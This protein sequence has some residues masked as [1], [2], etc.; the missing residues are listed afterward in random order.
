MA[1]VREQPI[2]V[3]QVKKDLLNPRGTSKT[4]DPE[5]RSALASTILGVRREGR[6][7]KASITE[8][9]QERQG[10][11]GQFN[12]SYPQEQGIAKDL[13]LR[14]EER[15]VRLKRKLGIGDKRASE[16]EAQ[17]MGLWTERSSISDKAGQVAHQVEELK[18]KQAEIPDPKELLKAYYE[19]Q[20]TQPLTNQ[21]KRELL[22]PEVLSSLTTEEY[23]ALWRRL[24]PY[25]LSHVTRQGFR[26]HNVMIYHSGGL[27]EFHNGFVSVLNDEKQLRPPL[28]I[29]GLRT[30]DEASVQA[31]LSNWVLEAPTQQDAQDRFYNLV[32]FSLASA[33]NYPDVTA[34]HL[35]TQLVADEFYGGERDNEVF[36]LYPSDVI[37]SQY[38]FA[39][40]GLQKDFT[41]PQSETEWNDVFVWPHTVDNPGIPVDTGLVFLPE[42]TSVDPNT[43][44]KYASEVK[45]VDG[46]E[47]RVLVEDSNLVNVFREWARNVNEESPLKKA[48]VDFSQS[49]GDFNWHEA[50][51]ILV[52]VATKELQ[53]LGFSEDASVAFANQFIINLQWSRDITYELLE[54]ELKTS[55]AN[56]KRA[57]NPIPAK[58][59]WDAYFTKNPDRRPKHINYYS[60]D[61]ST[62]IYEFQQKNNIGRADTSEVDGKL[63]GFD[64]HHVKLIQSDIVVEQDPRAMVGCKELVEMGNKIITERYKGQGGIA[65]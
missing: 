13:A 56:W 1:E 47:Q 37:A 29:H 27:Q 2:N 23:I 33:P 7:T 10:L 45:M 58:D 54:R 11:V 24:N 28:A 41:K 36:F 53:G 55:G 6:S 49:R 22:V 59:Y 48:F 40:N 57:E 62:A 61:P 21:E 8:K 15:L 3:P 14:N 50:R 32:H 19:K 18:Q 51:R 39:F 4:H 44:S 12:E 65:A 16:L 17:L 30:R 25:F 60:G 52:D 63:L 35:A 5:G 20:E 9:E 43:G 34:V 64:D 46:K 42:T 26:D 38:N 31:Y